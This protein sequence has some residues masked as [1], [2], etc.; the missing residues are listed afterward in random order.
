V[1]IPPSGAAA[2]CVH[3]DTLDDLLGEQLPK[4]STT[5]VEFRDGV[6][7]RVATLLPP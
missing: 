1:W 5:L 7:A 3:K 6:L 4:A 2:F